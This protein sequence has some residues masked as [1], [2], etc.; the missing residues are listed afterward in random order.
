METKFCF[1]CSTQRNTS[2]FS[3]DKIMVCISCIN[4]RNK[5]REKLIKVKTFNKTP[6]Q[7][8]LEKTEKQ[9]EAYKLILEKRKEKRALLTPSE[10]EQIAI[11]RKAKQQ[12]RIQRCKSGFKICSKCQSIKSIK[13]Y[14]SNL[15]KI[16]KICSEKINIKRSTRE[17]K[18]NNNAYLKAKRDSLTIYEKEQL[19]KQ[20]TILRNKRT[21]QALNGFRVCSRCE[22]LKSIDSYKL[23]SHKVC[24][25][26]SEDLEHQRIIDRIRLKTGGTIVLESQIKL[27]YALK[28]FRKA[29][30]E[31]KNETS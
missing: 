17:Y 28:T 2:D 27:E 15:H 11:K 18:D 12:E 19:A 7:Q 14:K 9:N 31:S 3:S 6:I 24:E 30:K 16:C 26:C 10:K 29:I 8:E 5:K 21:S 1:I 25:G 22:R 4:K 13:L 23:F 20:R